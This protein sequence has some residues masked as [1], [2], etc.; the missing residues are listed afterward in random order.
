MSRTVKSL[1][2]TEPCEDE[3]GD[4]GDTEPVEVESAQQ[5]GFLRG[6]SVQ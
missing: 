2:V 5:R 4:P 1:T 3:Q 6:R